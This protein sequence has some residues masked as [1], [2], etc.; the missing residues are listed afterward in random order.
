MEKSYFNNYEVKRYKLIA[1][2]VLARECYYAASQSKNIIDVQLVEQGLHDVGPKKMSS[3]LQRE[4]NRVDPEVYEAVLLGY[5]LC[6]NGVVGLRASLPMVLPRGHD[7]ITILMGSKQKFQA[8]FA[9]NPGSFFQSAGWIEQAKDN[10]SN[11]DSVTRQMG[12]ASYQ[13][14]VREYG[15]EYARYLIE[16][17]G[18]G[19]THYNKFTYID[20][21]VGNQ[22]HFKEHA[23]RN[24]RDNNWDFEEMKGSVR[25]LEKLMA[26]D[27]NQDEFLVV[28]AGQTIEPDYGDDVVKSGN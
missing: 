2:A 20:T 12:M 18:G 8:Y 19:L 10:L 9:A 6:N 1:C 24:A 15:E 5:G 11:P 27:W 3:R 23:R 7:C 26:G 25:L 16:A 21:G 13:E 17:M 4:I 14:Y 22:S 28:P